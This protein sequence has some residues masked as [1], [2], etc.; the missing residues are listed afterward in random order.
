MPPQATLT[1]TVPKPGTSIGTST[2]VANDGTF[3]NSTSVTRPSVALRADLDQAG[4]DLEQQR[5]RRLGSLSRPVS[6]STVVTTIRFV[7]DIV[8]KSADCSMITNPA[9][10]RGSVGAGAR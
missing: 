6:S 2:A 10:A 4:R 3:S 8:A 9:S 1:G 5:R 7:P